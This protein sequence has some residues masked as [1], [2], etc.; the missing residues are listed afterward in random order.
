MS[1]T[2]DV[3]DLSSPIQL[4]NFELLSDCFHNKILLYLKFL[5]ER[6]GSLSFAKTASQG[7]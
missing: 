6:G 5:G 4:C 3:P 1:K 7:F 2:P